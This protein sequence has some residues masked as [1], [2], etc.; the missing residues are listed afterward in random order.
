MGAL[1][2]FLPIDFQTV[3]GLSIAI[4]TGAALYGAIILEIK[5]ISWSE[6]RE[7]LTGKSRSV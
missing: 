3:S 2:K 1:I 6:I 5:A 7:M 4:V